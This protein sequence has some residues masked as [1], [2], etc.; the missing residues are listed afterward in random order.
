MVDSSFTEIKLCHQQI[1]NLGIGNVLSRRVSVGEHSQLRV[2]CYPRGYRNDGCGEH[3]SLSM[4]L[5][6]KSRNIRAV[7]EAFVLCTDGAS[8]SHA[9]RS[10]Q[11][12]APHRVGS[13]R[14]ERFMRRGDLETLCAANGVVKLVCGAMVVHENPIAVPVPDAGDH[15]GRLPDRADA[16]DVSF[17]VRGHVFHAHSA[18]LASR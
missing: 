1:R 4:F 15:L 10:V 6:T 11:V 16:S 5:T 18:V 17:S 8:Q 3:M 14:W 2:D 7:F 12:G 9:K 13:A